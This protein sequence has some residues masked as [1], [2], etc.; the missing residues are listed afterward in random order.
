[1]QSQETITEGSNEDFI[2]LQSTSKEAALS[3]KR[4]LY[5]LPDKEG[6]KDLP[7]SEEPHQC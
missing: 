3:K 1:M 5:N 2:L 6:S 4:S 7:T